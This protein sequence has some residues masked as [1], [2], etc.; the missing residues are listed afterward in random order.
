LF[1]LILLIKVEKTTIENIS[2]SGKTIALLPG[3]DNNLGN[4]MDSKPVST[5]STNF[6]ASYESIRKKDKRKK[7]I[8]FHIVEYIPHIN[9]IHQKKKKE[10]KN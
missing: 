6:I 2:P 7:D 8:K 1:F 4:A 10:R 9:P 5:I 3:N